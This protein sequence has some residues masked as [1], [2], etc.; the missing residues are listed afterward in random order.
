MRKGALAEWILSLTIP[1]DRAA[2]TAG[3]LMEDASTRG[4]LWFWSSVLRT[5]ASRVLEDLCASPLLLLALALWGWLAMWILAILI[6]IP[7]LEVWQQILDSQRQTLPPHWA[8]KA[9]D[10]GAGVII[11]P[12]LISR[13]VARSSAGR[14]LSSAF[15]L[16]LQSAVIHLVPV[17]LSALQ[18]RRMGQPWPGIESWFIVLCARPFFVIAGAIF[19]RR[20]VIISD[21]GTLP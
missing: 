4:A 13:M 12:F 8:Y 15:A 3:D 7:A 14:E 20:R 16:N 6:G 18:M 1:R 9:I 5:A 10:I 2:S 17:Y 21:E 19:Y 11:A